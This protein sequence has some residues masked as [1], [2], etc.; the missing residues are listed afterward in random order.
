MKVTNCNKYTR[1]SPILKR[2]HWLPVKF[3]SIFKTATLVFTFLY[4]GHPSYFGP[5]LSTHRG[6]YSTRFNHPDKRFLD[7]FQFYPSVY[8]SKKH[9]GHS[10]AFDAPT[11]WND[12]PDQIHSAPSLACFRKKVKIVSLQRGFPNLAYTLSGVSVVLDLATAMEWWFFKLDS[13]VAPE[14]LPGRD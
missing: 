6:R 7:S 2:L 13:S 8:K 10:F 12:L 9:F 5:L 1:A 3:L 4:S 11:V 14:S